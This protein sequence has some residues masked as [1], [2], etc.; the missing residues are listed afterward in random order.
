LDEHEGVSRVEIIG[1]VALPAGSGSATPT[2][3][4]DAAR[5]GD[6]SND[7]RTV[8]SRRTSQ[9]GGS[10]SVSE[11][12]AAAPSSR[13]DLGNVLEGVVLGH[14]RLE[15]FVGGGGMGSVFRGTDMRLG[16]TVAI[17][18]LSRD[19]TEPETLRRFQNEAQSAARLDHENIARVYYVGEDQGLHFIV[20]EYI[21]GVNIRDLVEKK[22]PLPLGEAISY[23]LQVAEALEHASQR[24]VVHRDIKPSNILVTAD[25][26][27]KLVDMGLAR[28]RMES[29]REDLTASGVTLGTFDYIS[30][31]QARDPRIA[32]VR[33]DLYSL[34]CTFYF[35]LTSRPPFPEGT[36]L[37]KL[38]SHSSEQPADPR[39][40]RPE[41]DEQVAGIIAKLLAKQPRDRHQQPNELIGELLLVA[42][43]LHLPGLNLTGAVWVGSRRS[44]GARIERILPWLL[45]IVLLVVSVF[46]LERLWSGSG[47]QDAAEPPLRTKAPRDAT[48]KKVRVPVSQ[49]PVEKTAAAAVSEKPSDRPAT[50]KATPAGSPPKPDVPASSST[51]P[52]PSAATPPP[53]A[54]AAPPK[55]AAISPAS[56][57]QPSGPATAAPDPSPEAA[58]PGLVV[59]APAAATGNTTGS[60]PT[61]AA[62]IASVA[63]AGTKTPAA[64]PAVTRI[65]VAAA[66]RPPTADAKV[67][68]S[69]AAACREAAVLGIETIELHFDGVREERAFDISS[70]KLTICNGRGFRPT[71]VFRPGF[72]D[73]AGDRRMVR[74]GG[75][76]LEW[77]GVHLELELPAEPAD[78]WALFSL[79]ACDSFE[80]QDAVLTVRNSSAQGMLLQD[81][82]AL[83]EVRDTPRPEPPTP[84][85]AEAAAKHAIPPFIG[86]TNCVAR[87]Q[88]TLIRCDEATPLRISGR[89]CLVILSQGLL[90]V[91]GRDTKPVQ[92]DARIE[93]LLKNVTAVL[94][95]ELCC[96][97]SDS[98]KPFQL[99]LVTDCKNS[100]LYLTD[101]QAALIE[102][103]GIRDLGEL[104]KHLYIRGRDNFYPG[105]DVLL[106]LNPTGDPK[107]VVTYGFADRNESWYQEESPRFTLMWNSLPA[108]DL[109]LDRRRP[110][111]YLLDDNEQNP[112][113]YDGGET[114]AGADTTLLPSP[115]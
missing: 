53:A 58:N 87:G 86:L 51:Q 82:V 10:S 74:V 4:A 59:P 25:G 96:L 114:Q 61:P 45:P 23:L 115:D 20:F 5:D 36:L 55:P 64:A 100:I 67:V 30:P 40:I 56:P 57:A 94:G 93:L 91:G 7:E 83:L 101:T 102:R 6:V 50:R 88:A 60:V 62:E 34:G 49:K 85:V 24:H 1:D 112:A 19:R 14:F 70:S 89:Q 31:E 28:L 113:L 16:R 2:V 17:K 79:H 37:Q 52:S 12:P 35:M 42:D 18:V 80:L 63:G 38:L 97:S 84:T 27:A 65:I 29:D 9:S 78:G 75:G 48:P 43:R 54:P 73:L 107:N 108:T 98:L 44:H 33:S 105:S 92:T 11:A 110:A 103:R 72:K 46:A 77:S 15:K 68:A 3:D 111:D 21:E 22:G 66:D 41:I 47:E 8:I 71:L 32:D 76:T 99:D 69:L 81:R 109:P 104:E 106:R 90:D 13:A 26:R 39:L 95:G